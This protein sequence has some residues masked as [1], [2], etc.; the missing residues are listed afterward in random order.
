MKIAIV[1]KFGH[2][3]CLGFLLEAM[4]SLDVT[5]YISQNTDSLGW[6]D[7]FAKLY[8]FCIIKNLD[9]NI[10]QYDKI[11]RLTSNDKCLE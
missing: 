8:S 9:I 2:M 1:S 3:E 11:I 6:T 5:V 7:Y 4:K 10:S